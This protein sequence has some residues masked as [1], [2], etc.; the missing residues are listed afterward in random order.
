MAKRLTKT[1]NSLALVIE[2]PVLEAT[3]IAADTPLEVSTDGDVIIVSPVRDPQRT[4]KLKR[5]MARIHD[6]YAGVFRRLAE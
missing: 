4:A 1:G 2:R 3:R 6:R 5:G